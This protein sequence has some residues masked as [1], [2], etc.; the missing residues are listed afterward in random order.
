VGEIKKERMQRKAGK[1][2]IRKRERKN[3]KVTKW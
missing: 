2:V 3:G 1:K